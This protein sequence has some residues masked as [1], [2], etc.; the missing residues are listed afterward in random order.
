MSV[1]GAADAKAE[2]RKVARTAGNSKALEIPAR[3]GFAASGLV[4]LL[5][6]GLAIQ[7]GANHFAEADQSGALEEVAKVPG[8]AIVLWICVIGL[9]ALGLWLLIQA[10]LIRGGDT[11]K[12]WMRRLQNISKALAYAALGLT[13][14]AFAEGHRT[15]ASSSTRHLSV[16][17]FTLPGGPVLL[18]VVGLIAIG[19]GGYF[20]SKGV[21]RTFTRDIVLPNGALKA[22]MLVLGVVGYVAKGLLVAVAGLLFIVSAVRAQ[23]D[24]ASG[25]S[26][27]LESLSQL[28]LGV[29]LLLA[30]GVGLIA[31][32][33]YNVLRAWLARF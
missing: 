12:A 28:P 15:H 9:F 24:T 11:A 4:Q 6:G 1:S 30:V 5:L 14:L 16:R 2:A 23:P 13:A 29:F 19:V 10:V 25:L 8:G 18:V 17:I 3:V 32:G 26:G 21:G 22:V 7:L 27:A 20:V 33:V 31:S